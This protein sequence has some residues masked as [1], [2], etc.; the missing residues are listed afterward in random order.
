MQSNLR[1]RASEIAAVAVGIVSALLLS[2]PSALQ[3]SATGNWCS[4]QGCVGAM[5][6]EFSPGKNCVIIYH[7]PN[8]TPRCESRNCDGTG[9][10]GEPY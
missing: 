9:G 2:A 7:S 5:A 4:E 3:A 10:G 1:A 8:G 6:C